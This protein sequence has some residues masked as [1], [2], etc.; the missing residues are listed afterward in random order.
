MT[1]GLAPAG[2]AEIQ[3]TIADL[4]VSHTDA[5]IGDSVRITAGGLKGLS[6]HL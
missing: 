1:F 3:E 6:Q 2:A 5:T 4:T